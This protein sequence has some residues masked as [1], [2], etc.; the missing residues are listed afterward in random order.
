MGRRLV[1]GR[2]PSTDEFFNLGV[3]WTV[4]R[5][6]KRMQSNE[7]GIG[8]SK[9]LGI[10]SAAGP[11][12]TGDNAGVVAERHPATDQQPDRF[13]GHGHPEAGGTLAN[14]CSMARSGVTVSRLLCDPLPY[15]NV[16]K[17]RT[18]ETWNVYS[19]IWGAL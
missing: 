7:L 18:R 2:S 19:Y 14:R 13:P 11:A 4:S 16:L 3:S 5:V 12:V 8:F 15:K 17:Y 10:G 1:S 9:A 6:P